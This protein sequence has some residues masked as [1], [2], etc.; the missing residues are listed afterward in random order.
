MKKKSDKEQKHGLPV[1]NMDYK[2]AE[3]LVSYLRE[4]LRKLNRPVR[5]DELLRITHLPR[6]AKK[7]V[8]A[9]LHALQEQGRAVRAAG[10]WA[11]PARVKHA[12]GVL[13]VLPAGMGFVSPKHG[14]PD[15][16]IHPAAMNDAWHGDRVEIMLLPGRRGPNL[17]GRVTKVLQRSQ[18]ELPAH[19]LRRQKDG[20][21]LCAPASTRLQALFITDVSTLEKPVAEGDLLLLR[22]GEKSGPNLW[23]AEATLNLEHEQS[24][25]AQ[26]RIT[27]SNHGIPG[28]FGPDIAL[29]LTEL[30][31]NPREED[32]AGREDLRD[33]PFVTIDGRTARDFDDAVHVERKGDSFRLRVAIA[34]VAHYVRRNGALDM[35]ARQRGNSYYFPLSVEPMLPEILSNGLCSLNPGVPRLVMVA[36]MRFTALGERLEARFFPGVIESR[37]R[38]TYGQIKR[39]LLDHEEEEE[40]NLAPV[41]PMLREAEGLARALLARRREQGTL[42]FDLPEAVYRFTEG[43]EL[44]SVSARERHFGHRLI[45]EFM[46]AAN[47]AVAEFLQSRDV[48]AL[49]RVHQPPDPDKLAMLAQFLRRSGLDAGGGKKASAGKKA[50]KGAKTPPTSK[51]LRRVLEENRGAPQ[52]YVVTRLVLRSMMQARYQT[53]NE[54][55]FGLASDCYCHFTS[56]IRRYADLTVHRSLKLALGLSVPEGDRGLSRAKLEAAAEHINATERTAAEA[57]REILK[58]LSV[59]FL[60]G[61]EGE[62]FDGVI[63]GLTD[64]G[65]FV[66]LPEF[67]A[68]GMIRLAVLDDDY[69]DYLEERQEVRGRRTGRTF[70]LGQALRV[71][72]TDVHLARLEVNL[73]PEGDASTN[74]S[75]AGK[76]PGLRRLRDGISLALPVQERESGSEKKVKGAAFAKKS[77]LQRNKPGKR[78][79]RAPKRGGGHT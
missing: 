53:E 4:T 2:N 10:G 58:R 42:D 40:R 32:L 66:E 48:P 75:A 20:L 45:E 62:S 57:E 74:Q 60:R 29:A 63:A 76:A 36:D 30:P 44:C 16:Y 25:Q 51:D 11:V 21:W 39:G 38:L 37:A 46:I 78:A 34:D 35:E 17:E 15:I 33:T 52:E 7:Q 12:E 8:E 67:M 71:R 59:L 65:I 5:M 47:E 79:G 23:N 61:R 1:Q 24:P 19:A 14:G 68:E 3:E 28:P 72:L 54:G 18:A 22:P 69:Y 13:S 26:E 43:G 55:H 49:Y 27:K 64:F 31:P 9:A 77:S 41:L 70:R 56:P 6:K 73:V 50:G